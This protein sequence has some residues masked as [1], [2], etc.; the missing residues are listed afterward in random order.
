MA[1]NLPTKAMLLAISN[2]RYSRSSLQSAAASLSSR[3]STNSISTGVSL[4]FFRLFGNSGDAGEMLT[5][6]DASNKRQ[7]K[8]NTLSAFRIFFIYAVEG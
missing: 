3:F 1:S 6:I 8:P 7:M 5:P 2:N 4:F